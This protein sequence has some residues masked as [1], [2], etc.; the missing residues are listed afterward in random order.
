MLAKTKEK[1]PQTQVVITPPKFERA[2]IKLRSTAPYVQNRF[3]SRIQKG[4][5][6][7]MEEGSAK[8]KVRKAKPPKD[9]DAAYKD[10]LHVSTDGWFGIPATAFRAAMVDATRLTEQDMIRAKMAIKVI[11]HGLDKENFEPLV[12]MKTKGPKMHIERV[13][14]GINSMDLAS[15]GMY[16]HWE[17]D[18]EIE[19]DADIFTASDIVNLM[20]RAGWQVGVGAGRPL[21]RSSVGRGWGTWEVLGT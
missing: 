15:R 10:S 19:W 14:I 20:A 11:G 8:K 2:V 5:Q 6:D 12:R 9:F 1:G 13:R 16:D 21:S 7:T 3:S 17:A 18:V 4:I